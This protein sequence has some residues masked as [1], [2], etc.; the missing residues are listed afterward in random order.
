[1]KIM[2]NTS[3]GFS[4]IDI[5]VFYGFLVTGSWM[6]W[7]SRRFLFLMNSP[8]LLA[9]SSFA[10]FSLQHWSQSAEFLD[11]ASRG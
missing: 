2:S 10:T 8:S 6:L 3:N 9:V 11:I 4:Y 1:M 5:I 7:G